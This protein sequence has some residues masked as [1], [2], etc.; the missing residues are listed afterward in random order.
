MCSVRGS[1]EWRDLS[2]IRLFSELILIRMAIFLLTIC[3]DF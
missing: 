1:A 3:Y 2:H